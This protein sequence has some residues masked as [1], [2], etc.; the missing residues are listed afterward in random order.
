MLRNGL[1]RFF[2]AESLLKNT[3]MLFYFHLLHGALSIYP[4]PTAPSLT[5]DRYQI[6]LNVSRLKT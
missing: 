1:I 2:L 5:L 3:E 4:S 6:T